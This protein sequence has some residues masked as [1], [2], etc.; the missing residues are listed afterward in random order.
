M[1]GKEIDAESMGTCWRN[2]GQNVHAWMYVLQ[3]LTLQ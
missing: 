3:S 1:Q 2:E